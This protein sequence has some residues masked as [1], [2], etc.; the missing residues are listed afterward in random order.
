MQLPPSLRFILL[1]A[2]TAR[3]AQAQ[4]TPDPRAAQPERPTVA[5]HAYAVS[6]GYAELETGWEWDNNQDATHGWSFPILIKIG[7][8]RRL[9]LGLQTT[10]LRPAGV[11]FG[12]G[13]AAIVGK[14]GI[15]EGTPLLGDVAVLGGL[16]L[17]VAAKPRGTGTTDGTL[18]LI[19]SHQFG[20]VGLDVN[21]GY[22]RRSGDGTEA[23]RNATLATAAFG[24]PI[25]GALG[26]TIEGYTYPRTSGPA[27]APTTVA[28][29]GGPTY[30]VSQICVLDFGGIVRLRGSQP[31]ALYGGITYNLGRIHS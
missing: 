13:D 6:P 8:A 10:L 16:K 4:A 27:G 22:T 14:I 21:F 15:S 11:S 23:P 3:L 31:N 26:F 9:Q 12:L 1:M 20:A 17:P 25:A 5:T 18:L 19:S 7:L 28:L 29:L 30:R 24:W 2:V